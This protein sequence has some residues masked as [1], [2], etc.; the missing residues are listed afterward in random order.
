MDRG[1]TATPSQQRPLVD[2]TTA[3]RERSPRSQE[4]TAMST[5][6]SVDTNFFFWSR[7]RRGFFDLA[8]GA[9]IKVQCWARPRVAAD[10]GAIFVE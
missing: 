10:W 2:K 5:C 1:K 7:A 9:R 8:R 4:T 3:Q 6:V